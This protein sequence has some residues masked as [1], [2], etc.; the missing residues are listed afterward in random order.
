MG[1]FHSQIFQLTL[2]HNKNIGLLLE[3]LNFILFQNSYL[4][5]FYLKIREDSLSDQEDS[6]R[7]GPCMSLE[8]LRRVVLE[9]HFVRSLNEI[10]KW[11]VYGY[12][13]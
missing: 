12:A 13:G 8:G 11:A 1:A 2:L 10:S 3:L 6:S 9:V 7:W 4:S 5:I